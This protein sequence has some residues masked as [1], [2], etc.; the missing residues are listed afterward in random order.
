MSREWSPALAAGVLLCSLTLAACS[1]TG[2]TAPSQ[3][4]IAARGGD[5]AA[6]TLGGLTLRQKAAQLIMPRIGGE[7][8]PVGTGAYERMRYWVDDLGVGGVIV[9]LGAPMELAAKLNMLQAMADVPLLVA[10]DMEH[11]PGQVLTGGIIL[12]Y[13]MENGGATRFPP[14]MAL[15]AAGDEQLA[16]ELG[17]I[18]ALEGRAAGVHVAFAPVVD[19]NNN[20]ANPIIN[21]RSFGAE[22]A[23]VSRLATAHIRGLQEH[24]MIATAKHFPGHGDTGTDS[25]ID[26]PV[27]TVDR[28]R[29]DRIELPPY[30]AAIDAGLGAVMSAHIAF[31]ALTGDSV[32]ATLHPTLL[33]TLLRK[34]LGFTGVIFTDALD[35]GAIVRGYGSGA[36][37]VMALRAGGDMLLQMLPDDVPIVIDAIVAAVQR[38][39]LSEARLDESLLRILRAKQRL[40]LHEQRLVS[41]DRI[42]ETVGIEAHLALARQAA[43]RSITVVRNRAGTLPLRDQRVLSIIYTDDAEPFAGRGFQRELAARLPQV[44]T[45]LIGGMTGREHLATLRTVADSFDVVLFSPFIRV[46][47]GKLQLAV[48][49][50]VAALVVELQQ[51]KPVVVTTF[52]SPYVLE[53]F[54]GS[55]TYVVAWG[56]WEPLQTAAARA[57]TG[58]APTTGRLPIPIPPFHQIGEGIEI[59]GGRAEK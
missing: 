31:P 41:L 40:G 46:S 28:A 43:Q 9:S 10:A 59:G 18:T 2:R 8:V 5:W 54:P 33:S 7:Y 14:M 24:G 3:R 21:T 34:E 45:A 58:A 32:P 25:H 42:P 39:E 12:P 23:L 26:L 55:D 44:R 1:T 36:A 15:G 16:Y 30:R 49:A 20:P 17:R 56:Q 57:L 38:G 19:V 47:A 50:Q 35:M 27:I 52:G 13:G 11:G 29:V 48:A 4:D 22:P 6:R 37:A 53:Q 51:R